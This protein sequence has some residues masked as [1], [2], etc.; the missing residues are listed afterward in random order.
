MRTGLNANAPERGLDS[1]DMLD[2]LVDGL[3]DQ[4]IA[5]RIPFR[6]VIG[7]D[8]RV[9]TVRCLPLIPW[10]KFQRLFALFVYR[11]FKLLETYSW[12][13][14]EDRTDDK[15][16]A[17][18]TGIMQNFIRIRESHRMILS[19]VRKTLFA[20]LVNRPIAWWR[21]DE[22]KAAIRKGWEPPKQQGMSWRYFRRN[23]TAD[24]LLRIWMALYM[25]N[26][27]AVKKN[28]RSLAEILGVELDSSSSSA[29]KRSGGTS[30]GSWQPLFPDSP[31][32][33]RDTESGKVIEISKYV[34]RKDEANGG[35]ADA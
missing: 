1:S 5:G 17:R 34:M 30:T 15:K 19:I 23:V 29:P 13:E 24:Q 25:Y 11:M 20:D 9:L 12:P 32:L 31:F 7:P 8:E 14:W 4:T 21:R 22:R 10:Q 35:A 33:R 6:V 16:M 26:I 18:L 28:V 2:R 3:D 27:S